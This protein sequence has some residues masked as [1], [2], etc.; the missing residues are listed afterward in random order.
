MTD[1]ETRL[2]QQQAAATYCHA[3]TEERKLFDEIEILSRNNSDDFEQGTPEY[4]A[5]EEAIRLVMLQGAA[6]VRR[7]KAWHRFFDLLESA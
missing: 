3:L 4:V 5:G 7:Q 2:K 1:E 6:S